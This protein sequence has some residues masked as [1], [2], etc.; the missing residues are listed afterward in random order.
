MKKLRLPKRERR[1]RERDA[2]VVVVQSDGFACAYVCACVVCPAVVVVAVYVYENAD[3]RP[4][5]KKLLGTFLVSEPKG[6]PAL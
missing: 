6:A 1:G 4:S 5:D 2:C 3:R